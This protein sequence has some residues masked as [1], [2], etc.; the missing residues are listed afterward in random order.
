M[1]DW[2]WQQAI[3]FALM[4]TAA[5]VCFICG[6][7]LLFRFLKPEIAGG[8]MISVMLIVGLGFWKCGSKKQPHKRV[9]NEEN[10]I[11]Q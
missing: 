6:L 10:K 4:V 11:K 7:I 2:N 1:D 9:E 5:I 8:I 3:G